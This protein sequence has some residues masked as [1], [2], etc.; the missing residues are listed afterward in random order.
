MR[1]RYWHT[2][3]LLVLSVLVSLFIT[4]RE[5]DSLSHQVIQRSGTAG[6]PCVIALAGLG[7]AALLD[8]FVNDLLP[9]SIS[10]PA[11]FGQRHL[12]YM[13]L[14][15]GLGCIGV[16]IVQSEG[17]TEL[18]MFYGLLATFSAHIA[19]TDLFHRKRTL[20]K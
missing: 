11:F 16:V 7:L 2:R 9:D 5:P 17:W 15:V 1:P 13:G 20:R 8:I 4:W 14:A 12:V 19:A 3:L 18:L 6:W 10:L